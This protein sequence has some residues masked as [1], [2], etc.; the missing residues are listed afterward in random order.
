MALVITSPCKDEMA[1]ECVEVC[2]VDCIEEGENM[3][4]I[5]PEV[6]INCNAC[7]T[8]CPVEAIYVDDEVPDEEKE[9]IRLNRE[10]FEN[11]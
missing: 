8:A 9:Y 5:D 1:A 11:Q 10:F 4:F 6:C 2:P 3:F 7:E